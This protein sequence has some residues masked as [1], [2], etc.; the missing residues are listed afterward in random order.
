MK[1]MGSK[2]RH[3]KEL[4]PIILKDHKPNMWYVE[5]FVGGANMIDKVSTQVAPKR[6]GCDSNEYLIAMWQAVSKGWMPPEQ[7]TEDDYRN[8]RDN[9]DQDKALTSYVGF[10]MSFGGKW[11]GGYRRDKVGKRNYSAESYRDACKQFPKLTGVEFI[12]KSVF[13]LNFPKPCTIY[14]DPP[15]AGTTKYKDEFDHERFYD[16]C[17]ERNK[18][19]HKVFISEYWMP[20]D[21]I[22]VW[23]KQV[24]SSLNKDVGSKKAT[25]RLYT[26]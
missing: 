16:W 8:I 13:D 5:P 9:K 26:L 6:I 20:D 1:Y 14:C 4:L 12:N 17:R 25:E 7:V 10:S 2:A 22:C 3:A 18:E 21:F 15:Y 19:G 23:E 24:N 11:F